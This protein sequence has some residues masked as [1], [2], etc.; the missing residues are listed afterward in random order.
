MVTSLDWNTKSKYPECLHSFCIGS[1]L[2]QTF[3]DVFSVLELNSQT[4]NTQ[5]TLRESRLYNHIPH[6]SRTGRNLHSHVH[7]A[8]MT[9]KHFQVTGYGTVSTFTFLTAFSVLHSDLLLEPDIGAELSSFLRMARVTSMT[10]GRWRCAADGE[11]TLWRFCAAKFASGTKLQVACCSPPGRPSLSGNSRRL[12]HFSLEDLPTWSSEGSGFV[13]GQGLGAGGGDLQS[14]SKGDSKLP[15]EHWRPYQPQ[16]YD[17]LSR[18]LYFLLLLFSLCDIIMSG[19]LLCVP[20]VPNISL[21]VLKPNFLEI[22]LESHIVMIRVGETKSG[23]CAS[24]QKSLLDP[25][26]IISGE[27]RL[28][29]QRQRDALQTLALA[30]QL[31]GLPG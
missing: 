9:K 15:V 16:V 14:L 3:Y 5:C 13:S 19:L 6:L 11:A 10:C 25:H 7:V 20:A 22:L 2:T 8:P 21:S 23:K 31:P 26:L 18:R 29:T 28:K 17:Q 1:T 30:H 27:Q 4:L 24:R 12:R